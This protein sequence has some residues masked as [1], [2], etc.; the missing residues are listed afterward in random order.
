MKICEYVIKRTHLIFLVS[1]LT[2]TGFISNQLDALEKGET[3]SSSKVKKQKKSSKKKGKKAPKKTAKKQQKKVAAKKK[4]AKKPINKD[5]AIVEKSEL[6]MI[7]EDQDAGKWELIVLGS[8]NE[9]IKLDICAVGPDK[10]KY[11]VDKVE[12]ALYV[13]EGAGWEKKETSIK[14]VTVAMDGTVLL[15]N[16]GGEIFA[17]DHS[18]GIKDKIADSSYKWDS[19]AALNSSVIWAIQ[20]EEGRSFGRLYSFQSTRW[21]AGWA[22]VTTEEGNQ[23]QGIKDVFV[24]PGELWLIDVNGK[25]YVKEIEEWKTGLL[26]IF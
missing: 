20:Y 16:E 18:S 19:I 9:K 2:F 24:T 1:L 7:L 23:T 6:D 15:L 14:F 25:A 8:G 5:A 3:K 13:N 12:K 21:S 22:A 4:V 10:V 11:G 17:Y 26:G